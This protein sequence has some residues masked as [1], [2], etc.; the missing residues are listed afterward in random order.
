MA[1]SSNE[2]E[3][4][5]AAGCCAQVIWIKSQLADYDV[6]YDKLNQMAFESTSSQQSQQ[7]LPSSKVNFKCEEGTIAFNDVI[8]LLE[9]RNELYQRMLSFHS[10]CCINKALTLQSSAMYVEYLLEFWYTTEVE[11]ETKTITFSLS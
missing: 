1:M 8:S 5:A 3:Y 6:L 4:V 11:E 9:Y 7:L 10:N 2:A